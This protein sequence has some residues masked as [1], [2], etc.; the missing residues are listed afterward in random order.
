MLQNYKKELLAIQ[1]NL[2]SITNMG[3]VIIDIEGEYITEKTNYSDFCKAFRKNSNLSLFCEKCD[4]KALNKVLISR[5]PYIYKCHSGLI[6]VIIPIL[7]EGEVIGAFL[8]GQ[9]LLEDNDEFKIEKI[10]K[11]N[12]GKNVDLKHL[13]E[14][15][16]QLT[17]IDL[18]RLKNIISIISYTTY[19]IADCIKN[20][21]WLNT[22]IKNNISHKKIEL[23]N[24][25][26]APIIKFINE[27]IH[28]NPDLKMGATL[29]NMSLSQFSR[30]FKK[31]TGKN[32]KEYVFVKKIEQAKYFIDNTNKSFSEISNLL[33]FEDSSYFTK[34]FKKIE[35]ITPKQYREKKSS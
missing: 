26:I 32:F 8:V 4:L 33:N 23:S 34:V 22:N 15:Y 12:I 14:K 19:Y 18:N 35:G 5:T 1:K 13:K 24:S 20:Q 2:I 11:E 16:N 25:K 30:T 21:K 9:L 10:L 31:E 28:E 6:D 29:C 3:I 27:N 7:Y 17:K